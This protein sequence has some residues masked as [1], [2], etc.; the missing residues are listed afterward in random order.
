[1][2]KYTVDIKKVDNGIKSGV[3]GTASIN[4][5][6]LPQSLYIMESERNHL[7]QILFI[8]RERFWTENEWGVFTEHDIKTWI[9]DDLNIYIENKELFG[10]EFAKQ[11]MKWIK[12]FL[13]MYCM[14]YE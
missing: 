14:S 9:F 11:F 7:V 4:G 8:L 2:R 13:E 12:M 6:G 5:N 3:F 1:M 10:F